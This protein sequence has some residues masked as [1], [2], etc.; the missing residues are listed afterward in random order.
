NFARQHG[1]DEPRADPSELFHRPT[2][3]AVTRISTDA[4]GCDHAILRR[5]VTSGCA[6]AC[7]WLDRADCAA[8]GGAVVLHRRLRTVRDHRRDA[9]AG[10]VR[11]AGA[12]AG[13]CRAARTIG[14]LMGIKA[15]PI[16]CDSQYQASVT[17]AGRMSL[18]SKDMRL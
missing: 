1:S 4:A 17:P 9:A 2:H 10:P 12:A 18:A 3:S 14:K 11:A 16:A 15:Q 5:G 13:D 6:A 7:L 8:A